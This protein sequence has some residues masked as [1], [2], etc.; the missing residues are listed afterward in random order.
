[1]SAAL[2][3]SASPT[4]AASSE[5]AVELHWMLGID[6]AMN[7]GYGIPVPALCGAWIDPDEQLAANLTSGRTGTTYSSCWL[8]DALHALRDLDGPTD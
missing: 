2:S 7:T 1:M 4:A 8:C 3:G 5:H 6:V